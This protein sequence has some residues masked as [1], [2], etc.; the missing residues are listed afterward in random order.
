MTEE[1]DLKKSGWVQVKCE[2][3]K[4]WDEYDK[5]YKTGT[6]PN[7]GMCTNPKVLGAQGDEDDG[8]YEW[9]AAETHSGR[10]FGCIHW[11]CKKGKK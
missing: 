4:S 6:L 7:R 8:I 3:C 1:D 10:F 9:E 5:P 2:T 11:E